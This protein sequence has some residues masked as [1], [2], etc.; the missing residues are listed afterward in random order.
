MPIDLVCSGC[1]NKLRVGD[2][3]AGKRVRCPKC[4]AVVEVP[5]DAW[6][7]KTPDGEDYGPVPRTEL[8]EW[9]NEGRI[10]AECQLLREGSDQWQWASE[11][12][13]QLTQTNPPAESTPTP[14]AFNPVG[15]GP[16][17][18]PKF[19][20]GAGKSPATVVA[21]TNAGAAAASTSQFSFGSTPATGAAVAPGGSSASGFAFDAGGS[22]AGSSAGGDFRQRAYPAALTAQTMYRIFGWAALVVGLLATVG[23]IFMTLPMLA[24][25]DGPLGMIGALLT[26]LFGVFWV[27]LYTAISVI[28]L[29]F[30]A[31]AIR[32]LMDIQSNTHRSSHALQ[33][34]QQH[35]RSDDK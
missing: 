6:Y 19:D 28:T 32:M 31:D 26:M 23:V 25:S 18:T 27:V 14:G 5:A 24:I 10:T 21:P 12:Y 7:L 13:S 2:Q 34:L 8:D 15:P 20:F 30:L 35:F 1:Q 33:Q 22:V 11:V 17:E 4:Q 29:W 16:A 9:F 3:N